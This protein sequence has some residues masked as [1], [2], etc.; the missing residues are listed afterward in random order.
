MAFSGSL[1]GKEVKHPS[2]D[3]LEHDPFAAQDDDQ[4]TENSMNPR[5]YGSDL[6]KVFDQLGKCHGI[7]RMPGSGAAT[8]VGFG[9]PDRSRLVLVRGGKT[10]ARTIK[11]TGAASWEA[12]IQA[13]APRL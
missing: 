12:P 2:D 7:L 11:A 8:T 1:T 3:N 13:P 6:R 5:Q 9:G 4:F 10:Y